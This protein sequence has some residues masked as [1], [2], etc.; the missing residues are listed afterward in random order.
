M[1]SPRDGAVPSLMPDGK[2]GYDN[3]FGPTEFDRTVES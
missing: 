2:E 3:K 1:G